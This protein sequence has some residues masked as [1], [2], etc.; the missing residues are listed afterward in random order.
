[1]SAFTIFVSPLKQT[2]RI[3]YSVKLKDAATSGEGMELLKDLTNTRTA[4][5]DLMGKW[6]APQDAFMST[7][8][9]YLSLLRGLVDQVDGASSPP[10][11]PAAAPAADGAAADSQAAATAAASGSFNKL[12][13][14][15]A[16]YWT[17]TLGK[18]HIS[19]DTD[20]QFELI[21]ML[22]DIAIWHTKKANLTLSA[23]SA[24]ENDL[25]DAYKLLRVA[26]GILLF[27]E[28]TQI[29]RLTTSA[30]PSDTNPAAVRAYSS[31]LLA[32]AEEVSLAR[33]VEKKHSPSLLAGIA[34]DIADKFD[35][36]AKGIAQVKL[37]K[38]DKWSKYLAWKTKYYQAAAYMFLGLDLLSKDDCGNAIRAMTEAEKLLEQANALGKVFVD[39]EPKTPLKIHELP[40]TQALS[41]QL[42]DSLAKA[43]RENDFIYF[44]KVPTELPELAAPRAVVEPE[45]YALAPLSSRWTAQM[46]QSLNVSKVIPD[47]VPAAALER[48][49]AN[50]KAAAKA[51]HPVDK[52]ACTIL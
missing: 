1:M 39:C 17:N 12:R 25:K 22:E 42:R 18:H 3:D 33:A 26:A 4:L 2:T 27:I 9:A 8:N 23:A 5:L 48:E 10:Q 40:A 36:A 34:R 51:Q 20:V 35:A 32:E 37:D 46:Y 49:E 47:V 31:Q 45:P 14:L 15:I 52:G 21:S 50:S 38:V 19:S 28:S 6:E 29:A 24:E 13:K 16:F 7:A 43:K 44:K 11:Q 30:S 41:R